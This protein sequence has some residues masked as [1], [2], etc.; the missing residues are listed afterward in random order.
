MFDGEF[1]RLALGRKRCRLC[2]E[3][4]WLVVSMESLS[5]AA[6]KK[7]TLLILINDE[8]K[9]ACLVADWSF[10]RFVF[11]RCISTRFRTVTYDRFAF[12]VCGFSF[13]VGGSAFG[14]GIASVGAELDPGWF[15]RC[16]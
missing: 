3:F 2:A 6:S 14:V 12:G 10:V 1:S 8:T 11:S 7:I 4:L 16:H 15:C 5:R 13:G 9:R